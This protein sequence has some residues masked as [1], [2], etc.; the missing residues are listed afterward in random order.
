MHLSTSIPQQH[1][2][3]LS[4]WG[5]KCGLLLLL[6]PL[7]AQAAFAAGSVCCHA[8]AGRLLRLGDETVKVTT[9]HA[10][11]FE[12][13][14]A[15]SAQQ[16]PYLI[17]EPTTAT[18]QGGMRWVLSAS[19]G[20][21]QGGGLMKSKPYPTMSS[22]R[23]PIPLHP[24]PL[25]RSCYEP[26]FIRRAGAHTLDR[27]CLSALS[28]SVSARSGGAGPGPCCPPLPRLASADMDACTSPGSGPRAP[29]P[30]S[31]RTP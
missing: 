11:Q 25:Y 28:A 22:H 20:A 12:V 4:L 8:A 9:G 30:G 31:C 19:A 24:P 29:R 23:D 14:P 6:Q 7:P 13:C 18:A 1:K 3:D 15:C 27:S 2:T 5:S 10:P 26:G 17:A 21:I 16:P